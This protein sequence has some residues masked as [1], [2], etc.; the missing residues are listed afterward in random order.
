[1]TTGQTQS[2]NIEFSLNSRSRKRKKVERGTDSGKKGNREREVGD[3]AR[4]GG[5]WVQDLFIIE[6]KEAKLVHALS[7][8]KKQK[9][10]RKSKKTS[11]EGEGKGGIDSVDQDYWVAATGLVT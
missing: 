1:L 3:I 9:G 4:G 10:R 7:S 8:Q 5:G 2:G 11:R 6:I